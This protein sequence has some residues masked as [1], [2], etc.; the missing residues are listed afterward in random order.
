MEKKRKIK[1]IV[2]GVGLLKFCQEDV[3]CLQ[4]GYRNVKF[5]GKRFDLKKVRLIAEIL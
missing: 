3:L 5:K 2:L 4:V 1:R